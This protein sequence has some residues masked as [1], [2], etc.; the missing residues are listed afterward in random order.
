[1]SEDER[2]AFTDE[3]VLQGAQGNA[4]YFHLASIAFLRN[5]SLSPAEFISWLGGKVAAL[6]E[7]VGE[8]GAIAVARQ[9]S[10]NWVSVGSTLRSLSGDEDR[11]EAVVADW[12]P[13]EVASFF[14]LS[15]ADGD[16]LWQIM[17]PIAAHLG[18][19]YQ[20]EREGDAVRMTFWR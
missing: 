3:E 4:N 9:A 14:E 19:Q 1:M 15:Q 17:E 7:L 8:G 10:L 2:T 12:P 6:W 5:R 13:A 20:W 11:A 18:L 16:S